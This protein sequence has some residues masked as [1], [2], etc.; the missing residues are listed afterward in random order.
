MVC[1]VAMFGKTY[2]FD[3]GDILSCC[4]GLRL[5]VGSGS[6]SRTAGMR[7]MGA[8]ELPNFPGL[9]FDQGAKMH[10]I[11]TLK[12]HTQIQCD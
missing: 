10:E 8:S 12:C 7:D 11:T 3:A 9:G 6:L 5:S 2:S 4:V 1:V